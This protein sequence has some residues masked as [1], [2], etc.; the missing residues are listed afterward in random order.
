MRNILL[1]TDFSENALNAAIYALHLYK[2][3]PC[4]FI[5]LNAYDID[6]YFTN[7]ILMPIPGMHTLEDA[8]NL[9]VEKLQKL[10]NDLNSDFPNPLHTF[11]TI[12]QNDHLI[13][14][15][16]LQIESS[17]VEAV[18]IGT[19]GSTAAHD[20]AYGRNTIHIMEE[21]RNCPIMAIP[22]HVKYN[23]INEVVLPTSYKMDFR[24]ENF[25]FIKSFLKHNK[26]SLRILHIEENIALS[27]GQRL[28]KKSLEAIMKDTPHSF[29]HL[30]Y[31]TVPIGIYCF[32]ESR[33]SDMIAFLNKKHSFLENVILE[34]LYKNLGNYSQ[35]PVLVLQL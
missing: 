28:K 8:K 17:M 33:G 13:N 22:S 25:N 11:S 16:I 12:S 15:I 6:G 34:P 23:G 21:V 32:T 18:I 10:V 3:E 7:S 26:A 5:F 35:I 29:H 19:Q 1:P 30:A 20:V 2:E 9:S 14:A 27:E 4:Q 24:P 31:V